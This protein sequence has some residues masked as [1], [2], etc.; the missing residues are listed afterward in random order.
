MSYLDAWKCPLL[1]NVDP[2]NRADEDLSIAKVD[3]V[4]LAT[5]RWGSLNDEWSLN[6]WPLVAFIAPTTA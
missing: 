3:A 5:C 1:L 6:G 2:F 4:R